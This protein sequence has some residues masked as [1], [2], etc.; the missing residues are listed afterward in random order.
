MK[1]SIRNH[2]PFILDALFGW[3]FRSE[4]N[5]T[6]EFVD[7]IAVGGIIGIQGQVLWHFNRQ[8]KWETILEEKEIF[9]LGSIR[10]KTGSNAVIF[11][12]MTDSEDNEVFDEI[13]ME[14]DAY[15]VFDLIGIMR[16]VNAVGSRLSARVQ[17]SLTISTEEVLVYADQGLVNLNRDSEKGLDFSVSE[18]E[19][20]VLINN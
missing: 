5:R 15:I 18:G 17:S 9:N 4:P 3:L 13:T 16:N 8:S 10:T 1:F 12:K 7:G 19:T 20:T 14:P 6:A 2:S 11:L